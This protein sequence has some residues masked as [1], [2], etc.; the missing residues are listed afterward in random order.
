M[1]DL[2]KKEEAREEKKQPPKQKT[3]V[4]VH[5][6]FYCTSSRK[7]PKKR[8]ATNDD[9]GLNRNQHSGSDSLLWPPTPTLLKTVEFDKIKLYSFIHLNNLRLSQA[10]LRFKLGL[11]SIIQIFIRKLAK[12]FSSF[13]HSFKSLS[14]Y[15]IN[16]FIH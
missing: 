7:I 12:I 4:I 1:E 10:K 14:K 13:I 11:V 8:Q 5:K 3:K 6:D 9:I 15:C 16:L 2:T